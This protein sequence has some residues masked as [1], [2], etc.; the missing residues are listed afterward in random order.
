MTEPGAPEPIQPPLTP[1]TPAPGTTP[2]VPASGAPAWTSQLT[3]REATPGPAGLYY[4]DVP[5][6]I[7]AI[8]IDAILL[9][10]V[11][12]VVGILIAAIFGPPITITTV[13]D[14]NQPLGFRF[15]TATNLLSTLVTTAIGLALSAG[16]YVYMWTRMRGT[17]GQRALGMQ[18]ANASDGATLTTE[19]AVRRWLALGGVFS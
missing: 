19:Q 10:I 1:A 9:A 18:V 5:N 13:P 14:P 12:A 7:I 16:Y 6:R 2:A 3:S 17:V 15:D 4:A 8:I 11:G